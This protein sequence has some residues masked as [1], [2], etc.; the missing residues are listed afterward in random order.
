LT[1]LIK[2]FEIV[3]GEVPNEKWRLGAVSDSEEEELMAG[4]SDDD[5]LTPVL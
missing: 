4:G 2:A 3:S 5:T 1:Y